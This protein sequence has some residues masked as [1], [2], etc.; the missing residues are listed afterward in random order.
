MVLAWGPDVVLLDE[1]AAGLSHEASVALAQTLRHV[2]EASG[3]TMIVVEHDMDIVRELADRV[4]VLANGSL[5][6]DGSMDDV[7]GNDRVRRAYLGA[8]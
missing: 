2:A 5:L 7:I 6:V 8:A 1:P 3:E 4:I